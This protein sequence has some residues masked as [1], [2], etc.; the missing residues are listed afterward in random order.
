MGT[1]QKEQK[2]QDQPEK[3]F[4]RTF[5]HDLKYRSRFLAPSSGLREK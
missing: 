2:H 1:E 3:K 4:L 5:K